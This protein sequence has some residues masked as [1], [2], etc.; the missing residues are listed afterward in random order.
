MLMYVTYDDDSNDCPWRICGVVVGCVAGFVLIL[1]SLIAL[2]TWRNRR[3]KGKII[4]FDPA[5]RAAVLPGDVWTVVLQY[6]STEPRRALWNTAKF[7]PPIITHLVRVET[8][9]FAC[10]HV[11]AARMLY[12]YVTSDHG[13]IGSVER[14]KKTAAVGFVGPI[15]TTTRRSHVVK[16]WQTVYWFKFDTAD[17]KL[18]CW[19][20]REKTLSL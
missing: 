12:S 2:Y 7:F 17:N 10:N 13:R 1:F 3:R 9:H 16:R 14:S 20:R 18:L 8:E 6:L 11:D 5:A 19:H 15:K 4:R